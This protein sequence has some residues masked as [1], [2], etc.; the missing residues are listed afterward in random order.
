MAIALGSNLGSREAHLAEAAQRIRAFVP[1]CRVSS[2]YET[3]YVG[4]GE[5]QPRY[6]NAAAVGHTDLPAR[7]LLWALL[8]I[9]RSLGRSRPYPDAPR[10]LD[11]DLVLY[12]SQVINEPDLVVPHP[13][14]RQ[15]RFVLEPLA[16]IAPDWHDPVTGHRID[17]LLRLLTF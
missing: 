16:E 12:G 7:Q 3:D 8:E 17:E 14:F 6:L 2:A 9:E 5:A 13:R 4:A 11:L 10:T 15:R 1:D